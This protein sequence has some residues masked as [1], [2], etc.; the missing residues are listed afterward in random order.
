MESCSYKNQRSL[1]IDRY[2]HNE[3]SEK[4][5]LSFEEHYFIC[6]ECFEELLET[7]KLKT[8]IKLGGKELF[9]VASGLNKRDRIFKYILVAASFALIFFTLY[10]FFPEKKSGNFSND[11]RIALID[12]VKKVKEDDSG[13]K[14]IHEKTLNPKKNI[15]FLVENYTPNADFDNIIRQNFR[16]KNSLQIISPLVDAIISDSVIFDWKPKETKNLELVILNNREEQ[17]QR[18]SINAPFIWNTTT[19]MPG[20]YYWK[21][22]T[23]TDLLY[24]GRFIIKKPLM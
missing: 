18:I 16:D 14:E 15:G 17:M 10:Q 9:A 7:E 4:D 20:L 13:D 24:I 8:T 1:L 23:S 12:T 11:S 21:L 3:L 22:E 6:S 5:R 2:L 19:V